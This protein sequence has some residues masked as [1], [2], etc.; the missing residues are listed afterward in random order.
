MRVL[1]SVCRCVP[2]HQPDQFYVFQDVNA[3]R[4]MGFQVAT[5]KSIDA[6]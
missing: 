3:V 4:Q 2:T 1:L 6:A 5:E